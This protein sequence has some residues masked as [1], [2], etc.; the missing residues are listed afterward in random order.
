VSG[1]FRGPLHGHI[2]KFWRYN[3]EFDA[4]DELAHLHTA[5]SYHSMASTEWYIA[6]VGGV[7]YVGDDVFHDLQV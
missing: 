3:V 4:W 7:L 1:G 6:V 5:R 2:D